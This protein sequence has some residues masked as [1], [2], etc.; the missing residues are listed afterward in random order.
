V[1]T[2]SEAVADT[3]STVLPLA[4]RRHTWFWLLLLGFAIYAGYRL[5]NPLK[6]FVN[7]PPRVASVASPVSVGGG[8]A[9]PSP[10]DA[11]LA[12]IARKDQQRESEIPVISRA[13]NTGVW[14]GA[15]HVRFMQRVGVWMFL[16]GP[17]GSVVVS[18]RSRPIATVYPGVGGARFDWGLDGSGPQSI[19][20]LGRGNSVSGP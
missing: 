20:G 10:S 11:D 2:P 12:D 17:S 3:S 7:S 15:Y 4:P 16:P 1:L 14:I 5:W 9:R 6:P 13:D 8:G 18:K 19:S